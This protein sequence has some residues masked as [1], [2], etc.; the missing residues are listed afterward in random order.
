M[1]DFSIWVWKSNVDIAFLLLSILIA[2]AILRTLKIFNLYTLWLCFPIALIVGYLNA[3]LDLKNYNMLSQ[4]VQQ[5]IFEYKLSP[6]S[7]LVDSASASFD[8]S[9]LLVYLVIVASI[10]LLIRLYLQHLN[11][12]AQLRRIACDD[13]LIID[14]NYPVGQVG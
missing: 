6:P 9:L 8:F 3:Y 11:L 10:V 5:A 1:L 13:S 2:R 4:P 7:L 12:Q 14:S